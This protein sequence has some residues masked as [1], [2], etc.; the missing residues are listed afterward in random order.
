MKKFLELSSWRTALGN[1]L[2]S[3]H[4]HQ[5]GSRKAAIGS[6]LIM[7]FAFVGCDDSSSASAGQN[8]EPAVESS[9]SSSGKVTDKVGEPAEG[10]S[11]SDKTSVSS[12]SSADELSSSSLVEISSCSEGEGTSSSSGQK[13]ESSSS[14]ASGI[15]CSAL[16]EG[17]TGWSWDVP[18]ECRF[19]PDID[20]GSMTDSRDGKVYK[21]VEIG[22]LVWMAENLN[23]ADSV[24]TT[25]LKGK[26]WCYND[27]AANCDVAGRLYTWAAAIDS[28]ALAS[29]EENPLDC[30]DGKTCAL[31]DTVYGVCPP[32]WHLP[33]YAEW[34]ALFKAVGGI[35]LRA[36]LSKLRA[37]G[38]IETVAQKVTA[39]TSSAFP[40]CLQAAG[41]T[42]GL[43]TAMRAATRVSG[44]RLSMVKTTRTF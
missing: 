9:S 40:R 32:D 3:A 28:V 2:P 17:E 11:S 7:A 8:D 29:D 35:E 36:G 43:T 23:Y 24:T 19:N 21:T 44:V 15:N 1:L 39:R 6:M 37:A 18:K 42:L 26:S 34:N 22:D 41:A 12:S 16:L 31:P 30:G 14:S 38:S 4:G 33:T 5:G 27:V 10:S 25:S 20:Y 13:I